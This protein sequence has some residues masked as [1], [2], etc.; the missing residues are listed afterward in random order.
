M[1][2]AIIIEIVR[3]DGSTSTL[4]VN[5]LDPPLKH[6]FIDSRAESIIRGCCRSLL[7][8]DSDLPFERLALTVLDADT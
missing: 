7:Q 4:S 2:K 1:K 6:H 3:A 8:L 5:R